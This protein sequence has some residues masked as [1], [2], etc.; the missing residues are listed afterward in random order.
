MKPAYSLLVGYRW[1]SCVILNEISAKSVVSRQIKP[2]FLMLSITRGQSNS[3]IV[4]IF[5]G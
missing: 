2:R 5:V 3:T 1:V 4:F